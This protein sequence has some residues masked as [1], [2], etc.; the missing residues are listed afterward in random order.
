M[1]STSPVYRV[2]TIGHKKVN[3]HVEYCFR[4]VHRVG[5]VWSVWRRYSQLAALHE[6]LQV[7]CR[8]LPHFPEKTW[9]PNSVIEHDEEFLQLRE[10]ALG[11]YLNKV[12][13]HPAAT[14]HRSIIHIL[15]VKRPGL[16]ADVCLMGQV[17]TGER[18]TMQLEVQAD[19]AGG[20]VEE[21]KL[22]LTDSNKRVWTAAVL[23]VS[24]MPLQIELRN[25]PMGTHRVGVSVSNATGESEIYD[26]NLQPFA[27]EEALNVSGADCA[28]GTPS[29]SM[30]A[31]KMIAAAGN[32]PCSIY[33]PWEATGN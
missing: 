2:D 19:K 15:D 17:Q 18:F 25:V 13:S 27:T 9:L 21:C 20:P 6:S 32:A 5:Q 30:Q 12:L 22:H 33:W 7:T 14:K 1:S 24:S 3:G 8:D 23:P 26:F 10:V 4:V 16:P 29:S 28:A 31:E 11:D